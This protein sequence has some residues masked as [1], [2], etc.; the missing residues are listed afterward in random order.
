MNKTTVIK[1][2]LIKISPFMY[3]LENNITFAEIKTTTLANIKLIKSNIKGNLKK[4]P[5]E[6][7]TF[8]SIINKIL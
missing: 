7:K 5:Q 8:H 1:N 2:R 4:T 3:I 6:L